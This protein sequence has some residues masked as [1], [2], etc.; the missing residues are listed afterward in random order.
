MLQSTRK[1]SD[2]LLSNIYIKKCVAVTGQYER[3]DFHECKSYV[4]LP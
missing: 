4:S 1:C 3:E 2:S